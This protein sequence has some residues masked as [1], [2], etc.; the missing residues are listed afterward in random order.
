MWVMWVKGIT[1]S[2][3]ISLYK[4]IF[5]VFLW[6]HMCGIESF[7]G[8]S[9]KKTQQFTNLQSIAAYTKYRDVLTRLTHQSS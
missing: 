2:N 7:P 9:S 1:I 4:Q 5:G 3:V 6:A 8:E